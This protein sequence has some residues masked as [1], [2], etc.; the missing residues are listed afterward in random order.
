M[1]NGTLENS[2][3]VSESLSLD[4]S[5]GSHELTMGDTFRMLFYEPG[6]RNFTY[7][8]CGAL[9]MIFL[10]LFQQG[11]DIGGVMILIIGAAGIFFRW[12]ASPALLLVVLTYFMVFPFGVPGLSYENAFEIDEGWFRVTD[13]MLVLSILV[14]MTCQFRLYG[15]VSR[16]I[17]FE[18]PVRRKDETPLRRPPALIH[19]SELGW[20]LGACTLFVFIG[21]VIWWVANSLEVQPTEDFPLR[22][23]E[24]L[25]S[26]QGSAVPGRMS[27]GV[28]RFV[29]MAGL[30]FF[31]TILGRLIFGYWRLRMMNSAEGGMS[32]LNGSWSETSRERQ[33]QELW[34]IWGRKRAASLSDNN[35]QSQSGGD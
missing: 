12:G 17:A 14:Y 13:V 26:W 10:I 7:A 1:S 32:I 27:P 15:F 4:R 33:R 35:R 8:A 3:D 18:G 20:V 34:R 25:R 2:S 9:G 5:D 6:V 28:T 11:S 29:V 31:G 30:L 21:Q 22:G 16:A 19:G 23:A 24:P